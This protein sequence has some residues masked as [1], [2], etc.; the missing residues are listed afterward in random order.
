MTFVNLIKDDN[1]E[2]LRTY[3]VYKMR[4]WAAHLEKAPLNNGV[5]TKFDSAEELM[6]FFI[7]D[8]L[9]SFYYGFSRD[10]ALAGRVLENMLDTM[11][12]IEQHNKE[13]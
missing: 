7:V 6:Q 2:G 1:Q 4:E 12:G 11:L 13:K 9:T 10:K 3:I 5:T 8:L